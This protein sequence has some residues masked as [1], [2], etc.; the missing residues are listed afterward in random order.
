MSILNI[1]IKRVTYLLGSSGLVIAGMF[2]SQGSAMASGTATWTGTSCALASPATDCFWSTAGNWVN[3]VVPNSSTASNV[4]F[5]NS[6]LA[7]SPS[8]V[9]VD[10]INGLTIDSITFTGNGVNQGVVWLQ[11]DITITSAIGQDATVQSTTNALINHG[12]AAHAI[13]LGGNVTVTRSTGLSIGGGSGQADTLALAGHTLLFNDGTAAV[14]GLDAYVAVGSIITGAGVVTFDAPL[15][16]FQLINNT[17]SGTTNAVHSSLPISS[18]D[19]TINTTPFGTSSIIVWPGSAI[20]FSTISTSTISNPI[21]ITGSSTPSQITSI[22]FMC[23]TNN[24]NCAGTTLS[25][26]NITLNGITRLAQDS[27]TN[28]IINLAGIT[29]NGNCLEYLDGTSTGTSFI[30]GPAF[31]VITTPTAGIPNTGNSKNTLPI[32]LFVA[33]LGFVAVLEIGRR[34]RNRS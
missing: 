11:Q 5:P 23:S 16:D 18:I 26:P 33:T 1:L 14:S 21:A 3:G 19:E 2:F 25:V 27:G 20:L 30:N 8:Q 6:I 4:I 13:T 32:T 31:C 24:A 22:N 28:M 10:D 15:T 34:I 7:G 9:P 12:G 29:T 17:Y